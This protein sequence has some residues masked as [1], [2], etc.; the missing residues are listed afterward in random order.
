[1]GQRRLQSRKHRRLA[2]RPV[3]FD[4]VWYDSRPVYRPG[5][6]FL[7]EILFFGAP[8]GG[9]APFRHTLPL[10]LRDENKNSAQKPRSRIR[11]AELLPV[12]NIVR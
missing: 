11:K 12:L 2:A 8:W 5:V 1:M 7:L 9:V 3:V 6:I 4:D 10:I